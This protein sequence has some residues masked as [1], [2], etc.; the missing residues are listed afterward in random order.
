M[1]ISRIPVLPFETT[2]VDFDNLT[3]DYLIYTAEF[4]V[5]A[6]MNVCGLNP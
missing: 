5:D 2:V 6:A 4:V 1:I 3:R